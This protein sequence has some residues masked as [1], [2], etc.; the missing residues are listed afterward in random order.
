[1]KLL[2]ALLFFAVFAF[3]TAQSPYENAMNSAMEKWETAKTPEELTAVANQFER[4]A[5]KDTDKWEPLYYSILAKT[6][7]SFGLPKE[8]AFRQLEKI[9]MDYTTLTQLIDNDETKVLKGLFLTVKLVH[10]PMVYGPTVP[11]EIMA[12][13]QAALKENPSN[14]RA[15]SN[16]AHFNME[17][18]AYWGQDAKK[19]CPDLSKAI[20]IYKTEKKDG[21]KP[22]W[23]LS[24]AEKTFAEK[25]GE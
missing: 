3:T 1:M 9:E 24:Q 23:G 21:Y 13:Y 20:E 18:A 5:A 4:I 19:Y 8:E 16:L 12:L 6:V 2:F 7:Y 11:Q 15:M 10:D 22:V 17:G 25:C 14:P